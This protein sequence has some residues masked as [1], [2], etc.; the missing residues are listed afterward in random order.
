[1]VGR[2]E[3]EADDV[4]SL[5]GTVSLIRARTTTGLGP[6]VVEPSASRFFGLRDPGFKIVG[7]LHDD[8]GRQFDDPSCGANHRP[9]RARPSG[10]VARLVYPPT[11][12]AV[13]ACQ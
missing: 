11:R 3:V 4:R 12:A 2:I 8:L 13:S 7:H 1:M 10:I 5:G 6:M 9:G